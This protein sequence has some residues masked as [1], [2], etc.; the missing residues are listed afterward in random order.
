MRVVCGFVLC[1]F[2]AAPVRAATFTVVKNL[3]F[4]TQVPTATSGSA[5]VALNG[6]IT[7]TGLTAAP[8]GTTHY[9]GQVSFTGT[10]LG[11]VANVVNMTFLNSSVV[12]SNGAGGTVSVSNFTITPNLQ[13]SLLNPTAVANIGAT[14]TFSSAST[15]GNYTGSVQIRGDSALGGTATVTLPITLT[16]WRTLGVSQ[17]RALNFGGVEATGGN[18]L[19]TVA[20]SGTRT[21]TS[22]AGGVRLI[23]SMPG[24]SGA[25]AITGNPNTSISISLP[26]TTTLSG[27]GAVMRLENF[28]SSPAAGTAT[29]D[30]SGNLTLNVGASLN[31]NSNQATGTYNGTYTVVVNY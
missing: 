8:S 1:V 17:T 26:S 3:S 29:L 6:N 19:I 27:P 5:V 12:L 25:F 24:T 20:P 31:I 10:G 7:R 18:S 21:I 11:T 4:G 13:I 16:L 9:A 23:P 2:A 30:A 14:M 15:P 22:G 28:V